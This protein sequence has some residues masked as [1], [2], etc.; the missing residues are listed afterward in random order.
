MTIS[1]LILLPLAISAAVINDRHRSSMLPELGSRSFQTSSRSENFS[2][3][4]AT[5]EEEYDNGLSV[6]EYMSHGAFVQ[7]DGLTTGAR[8][9]GDR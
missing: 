7:A 6:V 5:K 8:I 1:L 4:S 3:I 2:R 9:S